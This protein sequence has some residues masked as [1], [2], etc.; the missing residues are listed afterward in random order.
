MTMTVS[1]YK[2]L[3]MGESLSKIRSLKDIPVSAVPRERLANKRDIVEVAAELVAEK[4]E[5]L[6][7]HSGYYQARCPHPD[8]DDRSPSFTVYPEGQRAACWTCGFSGDVI[9]LIRWVRDVSFEE[10]VRFGTYDSDVVELVK[11]R[12]VDL[13][14]KLDPARKL[15]NAEEFFLLS[16][17]LF[18]LRRHLPFEVVERIC[19]GVDKRFQTGNDEATAF[20]TRMERSLVGQLDNRKTRSDRNGIEHT[21][22][23]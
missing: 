11:N 20:L 9:D 16:T 7:A 15:K 8:H 19:K 21:S 4:G 17:R 1:P 3:C 5:E 6:I 14:R 12:A 18:C 13:A 2:G 23:R 10:A 22:P